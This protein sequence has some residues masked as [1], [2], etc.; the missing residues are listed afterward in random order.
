M[1]QEIPLPLIIIGVL[2]VLAFA[3]FMAWRS[4]SRPGE[5]QPPPP[6]PRTP[7]QQQL[8]ANFRQMTPEQKKA[9]GMQRMGGAQPR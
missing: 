9:F 7:A 2:L 8:P 4:F 6:A 3:G 1:K 5:L